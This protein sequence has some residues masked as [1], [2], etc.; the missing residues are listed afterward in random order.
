MIEAAEYKSIRSPTWCP[1]CG[2]FSVLT[3]IKNALY[4]LQIPPKDTLV[5]S[6]IG[7]S[8]NLS[9]YLGTYT[10]HVIH[11]RTLPVATGARLARSDLTIIV[12]GG[13]GDGYGIGLGHFI[14]AMRRNLDVTYIVMN[15]QI[16]GL[17]T[18]QASPTS[19][20][21]HV[22]KTTLDGVEESPI[23]PL[24][25]AI[26]SGATFVARGFSGDPK[27]LTEL[28]KEGVKHRGFSLIDVL[29]PCVTFNTVNTYDWFRHRVYTID[30][31]AY[32]SAST[33][34]AL[35]KS[36][37]WEKTIP[38]GIIYRAHAPAYEELEYG[39]P[40][41][42]HLKEPQKIAEQLIQEFA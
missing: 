12:V 1:G 36:M 33:Q 30:D 39:S 13:D 29:S 3:A 28:M 18:G 37:E 25:L 31:S 15:N 40:A 34:P 5:I 7:C 21:G 38:L 6:G 16:Y 4:E 10:L 41:E 35:S 26:L 42:L 22:T 32:D 11:G 17:T 19:Q 23:N 27:Q 9:H 14:H 20:I 2:D 24:A 8:G